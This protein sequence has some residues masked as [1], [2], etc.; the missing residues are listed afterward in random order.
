[1][2]FGIVVASLSENDTICFALLPPARSP[3]AASFRLPR[4]LASDTLSLTS[5]P[6]LSDVPC[7]SPR[8]T[9]YFAPVA[10]TANVNLVRTDGRTEKT[11]LYLAP[12]AEG[13]RRAATT[14]EFRR[15]RETT[16]EVKVPR[17]GRRTEGQRVTSWKRETNIPS[18]TLTYREPLK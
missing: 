1:M 4:H 13:G 11:T 7:P 6:P 15:R 10:T 3:A 5:A 8:Q 17:E 18:A 2:K 16:K 12:A 14:R 9:N